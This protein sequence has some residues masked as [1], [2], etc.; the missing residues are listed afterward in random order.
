MASFMAVSLRLCWTSAC[1]PRPRLLGKIA[2]TA[3]LNS[4][5]KAQ[6]P[7]ETTI[8]LRAEITKVEGRKAW[9]RATVEDVGNEQVYVMA[10]ALFVQPK[11]ASSVEESSDGR[12][13]VRS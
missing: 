10:D 13:N 2:V 8:L 9:V 12:E 5:Y 11:W 1:L 4:N 3:N 7:V 6:I